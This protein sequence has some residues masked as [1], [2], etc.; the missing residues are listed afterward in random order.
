MIVVKPVARVKVL[1][2]T[3]NGI[4]FV[5]RVFASMAADSPVPII[6]T[7]FLESSPAFSSTS[8]TATSPNETTSFAIPVVSR[9]RAASRITLSNNLLRILPDTPAL[10]ASANALTISLKTLCQPITSESNPDANRKRCK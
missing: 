4:P 5:L 3:S 9:I 6:N 2:V 7:F 10:F 1:L 8:F